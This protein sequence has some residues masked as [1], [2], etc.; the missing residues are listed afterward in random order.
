MEQSLNASASQ[1]FAPAPKQ[2]ARDIL[3]IFFFKKMVFLQTFVGVVVAALFVSL[4]FPPSYQTT[5]QLLVRPQIESPLL[6]D[7]AVS[8]Y[9]ADTRVDAQLLNTV[10]QLLRSP[11]VMK[12]VV[13]QHGLAD[14]DDRQGMGD[15]V[16]SLMGRFSA[17]PLSPSNIIELKMRGGD[18]EAITA[19]LNTLIDAYI[20]YYI[21][22]NQGVKG[23][24]DFFDRQT[25]EYHTRL[26]ELT[27][28]LADESRRLN[29][30]NPALQKENL[31]KLIK[32]LELRKSQVL[33][34]AS[35]LN[36]QL[37][38]LN[39]A[40]T[41]V[42]SQDRLS[43]LPVNVLQSYPALVE[44]EKTLAQ[45][46]INKQRSNSDYLPGSKPVRDA[47]KQYE[48]MKQQIHRHMIQIIDNVKGRVGSLNKEVLQL[49][50]EAEDGRSRL[51]DFT[52]DAIKLEQLQLEHKLA[53][54]NYTLYG[55]KRE[56]ARINEEK[57]QA[58]FANVSVASRPVIPTTAYFPQKKKIMLMAIVLGF[59]LAMAASAGAYAM[60][61]RIYLPH[62][63]TS[64]TKL[65]CL[66]CLDD[67]S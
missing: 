64:R 47:S 27:S 57:D 55:T 37:S 58:Q 2:T 21:Q 31:L 61:Q 29:V 25:E 38:H 67:M 1:P 59:I 26:N 54:E 6:F 51:A 50:L 17:E 66:G 22:V 3:S 40:K 49:S 11:D 28:S 19:Q 24:L 7:K 60:D 32:D 62:D 63:I 65:R 12:A 18:P 34:E 5:A 35:S 4:L 23:R 39:R 52:A 9:S 42:L 30:A 13:I 41:G 46:I 10:L 43:G 44:M 20:A 53:K 56:E 48:N 15:E 45:L 14:E 33:S 16:G 8:R 36:E